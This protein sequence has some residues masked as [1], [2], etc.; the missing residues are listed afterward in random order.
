MH[1]PS[2]DNNTPIY[3]S[4]I[5]STYIRLIRKDYPFVDIQELLDYANMTTYEVA[6]E[7]HW[8]SQN[9][10]NRFHDKLSQLTNNENIAREAGRFAA[11]PESI[12][13]MRQYILGMISP[14]KAYEIAGKAAERF[15][16]STNYEAKKLSSNKV[17]INVTPR[18][19]VQEQPFQCENRIGFFDAISVGFTNKL[20]TIEHPE[21]VFRG[22]SS[23]R[24]IISWE[25]N[26]SD[27]WKRAR[28]YAL[29]FF[30]LV[31]LVAIFIHPTFM[32]SVILP[33]SVLILFLLSS[34][35]ERI[36]KN[37]LKSSLSHLRNSSDQLLEKIETNYNNA[38]MTNEIG[39][40]ISR[41]TRIEDVLDNVIN[42]SEKRLD[43]DRGVI[44]LANEDRTR[45]IFRAGFGYTDKQY[46]I[47]KNTAFHLD[48][49]ESTGVFILS[50]HEQKPFLVN[51]INDIEGT[52]SPRS[53]EFANVLE[54]KSFVCC[55]IVC[56]N[57]SLGI[58]A[59]DNLTSKRQLIQSDISLLLGIASVLGISIRNAE[60]LEARERQFN[61]L[62]QTL[63]A[64][65]DARDPLT[66]GHSIKVT[67]FALGICDEMELSHEYR[68]MIRVAALLHDYGKI[69]V[70]DAILLAPRKLT[71]EEYEEVKTHSEKTKVILDQ[72]NFEGIFSQVPII[73]GAHHE[74]MDGSGYPNGLKGDEIPLGAR[75]IAVADFFEAITAKR[76][77]RDPMPFEE[78]EALLKKHTGN[79]FDEEIV[80]S[81]MSYYKRENKI[82]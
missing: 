8:F 7:G 10:V 74:K 50:F 76:H 81:F 73:A 31:C 72:V 49:P 24:Y 40:A 17:E 75:I 11:S 54:T 45:L 80:S 16:K 53:V 69:G 63:A 27:V 66:A 55:P 59:V 46:D 3:N 43:Y 82:P 33:I 37:E 62:L 13:S 25:K 64:S 28:N 36:E 6:D 79:H 2:I 48:R 26:F 47:I 21:C 42:V 1:N 15:T 67:E 35:S 68:E 39:L 52:L 71:P 19:G 51:D 70:P 34:T 4:R 60:L 65:I 5:V 12:G 61:S 23:C 32:L 14:A 57:E 9:H 20:P 29:L 58:L 18:K 30:V 44:L 56:D 38:L 78:A 77:Y 22:G 41:H